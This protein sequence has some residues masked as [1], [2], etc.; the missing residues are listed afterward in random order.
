MIWRILVSVAIVEGLVCVPPLLV[1]GANVLL[2]I[3]L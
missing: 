1:A 2:H 3:G